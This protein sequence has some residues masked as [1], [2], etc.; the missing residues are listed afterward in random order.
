MD[1]F[2]IELNVGMFLTN[3]DLQNCIRVSKAWYEAFTPA[4]YS[5]IG[6]SDPDTTP[7]LAVLRKHAHHIR[8]LLVPMS[9][10]YI[11]MCRVRCNGLTRLDVV[12]KHT[13]RGTPDG[14]M[15]LVRGNPRLLSVK[16]IGQQ[17]FM[18]ETMMRRLSQQKHS[19]RRMHITGLSLDPE[20]LTCLLDATVRLDTVELAIM[21]DEKLKLDW[22]RWPSFPELKYLGL[23]VVGNQLNL[24]HQ[25]AWIRRCPNLETLRWN[26]RASMQR[27]VDGVE[28]PLRDRILPIKAISDIFRE[29]RNPKLHSLDLMVQDV[30]H[31][32]ADLE[33][34]LNLC[35]PLKRIRIP[36]GNIHYATFRSLER[37]F[38]TLEDFDVAG[39][40]HFTS[41][42]VQKVLTSCPKLRRLRADMLE[43]CDVVN[44]EEAADMRAALAAKERKIAQ[45][46]PGGVVKGHALPTSATAKA[47]SK[48]WV[49]SNLEVFIVFVTGVVNRKWNQQVLAQIGKMTRL[50]E[51]EVGVHPGCLWQIMTLQDKAGLDFRLTHGLRHLGNL[52]CLQKCTYKEIPQHMQAPDVQFIAKSWPHLSLISWK[53]HVD[54]DVT[55]KLRP[56]LIKAFPAINMNELYDLIL[57]PSESE[58]DWSTDEEEEEAVE[59]QEGDSDEWE[60]EDEE[61][62]EWEEEEEEALATGSL[63]D[64]LVEKVIAY[65]MPSA[66]DYRT[67]LPPTQQHGND[68]HTLIDK[69]DQGPSAW[70]L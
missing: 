16:F 4:L 50:R 55:C 70:P 5:V 46:T 31:T 49:C 19:L 9:G 41:A 13:D 32:D 22:N 2:E 12:L 27:V 26:I 28:V 3:Y 34:I 67:F 56:I 15:A 54:E 7:P 11:D 10:P 57:N 18:P 21:I 23:N 25:I 35:P 24:A 14:I 40:E 60:D 30:K 48:S 61:E 37:H 69:S 47:A 51:L 44:E 29:K 6:T 38:P 20:S 1:L 52:K 66:V 63:I 65:E 62:S 43:A 39:C 64:K 42:R 8:T 58:E 33:T 17:T 59:E 53:L 68:A 36:A 45:K